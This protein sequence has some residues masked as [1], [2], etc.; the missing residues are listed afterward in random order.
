VEYTEDLVREWIADRN[1]CEPIKNLL[2]QGYHPEQIRSMAVHMMFE[3]ISEE[4]KP[5][6]NLG[7]V[8]EITEMIYKAREED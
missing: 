7:A 1:L 8:A 6:N 3:W 5:I 4:N 2:K